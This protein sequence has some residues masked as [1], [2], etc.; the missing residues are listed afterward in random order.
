MTDPRT[1]TRSS[2]WSAAR[3]ARCLS[4]A[5]S[6]CAMHAMTP[7]PIA[8]MGELT[9]H[10]VVEVSP[11]AADAAAPSSPTCA[12]STY[13]TT[14]CSAVSVMVGQARRKMVRLASGSFSV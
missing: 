7:V 13:C 3:D 6:A 11:T 4:P 1:R 12:V 14:V 9:S 10:V 2:D 8:Q 5:P